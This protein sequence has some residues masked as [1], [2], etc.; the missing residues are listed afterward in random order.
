MVDRSQ[1]SSRR[2]GPRADHQAALLSLIDTDWSTFDIDVGDGD[3]AK[4]VHDAMQIER[5]RPS[6]IGCRTR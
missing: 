1:S 2:D 4:R 3:L 6:N 5:R